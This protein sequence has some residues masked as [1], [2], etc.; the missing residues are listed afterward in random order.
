MA[1]EQTDWGTGSVVFWDL[2]FLDPA[3]P[4]AEQLDGLKEDLAQ[5][6]YPDGVTLDIGWYPSFA[7]DGEFVVVV[8]KGAD[9]EHPVF[10]G[11]ARTL[12]QLRS[13]ITEAVTVADR[14]ARH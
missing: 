13:C 8:V 6:S 14:L 9:W 10:R 1:P 4:L 3:R 12:D 7:P 5:I 11:R 2:A